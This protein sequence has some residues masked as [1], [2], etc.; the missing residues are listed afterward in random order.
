[1][2]DIE[3]TVDFANERKIDHPH[4]GNQTLLTLLEIYMSEK[5]KYVKCPRCER[6]LLHT[7]DNFGKSP[8]NRN[9]FDRICKL[10]RSEVAS[11]AQ[12]ETNDYFQEMR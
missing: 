9:K 7:T 3:E 10:C 1:M 4:L 6:Q 11:N 8:G 12:Y 2:L 5:P